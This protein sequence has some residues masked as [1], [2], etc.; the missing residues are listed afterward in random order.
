MERMER[1]EIR[2]ALE[3]AQELIFQAIE[4]LEPALAGNAN[5]QAYLLDHL[6]ILASNDHGFLSRD[7]NLSQLIDEY[8]GEDE[9]D[10]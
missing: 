3:E 6:K 4:I 7:L 5:A 10:A 1:E 9:D 2:D 8:S